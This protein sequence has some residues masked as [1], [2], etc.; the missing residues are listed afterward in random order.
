[1]VG[2]LGFGAAAATPLG[3]VVAAGLLSGGAYYG[4]IQQARRYSGSRVELIPKF[5]NTPLDLLGASLLDLIGGLALQ[6]ARI[7]GSISEPELAKLREHFITEWRF[8]DG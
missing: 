8:D 7:D 2:W 6:L 5:I 4:V 3:W 1:M